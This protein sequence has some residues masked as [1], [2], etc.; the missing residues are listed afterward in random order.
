MFEAYADSENVADIRSGRSTLFCS[1]A[2]YDA[3]ALKAIMRQ[4]IPDGYN[5][6]DPFFAVKGLVAEYD[7]VDVRYQPA[8]EESVC[9][10]VHSMTG[11]PLRLP[12]P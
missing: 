6:F 11:E 12:S 7:G 2:L 8:R 5:E 3:V 1:D 10:H 4:V 9:M